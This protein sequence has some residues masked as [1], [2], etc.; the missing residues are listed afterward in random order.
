MLKEV[1]TKVHMIIVDAM[2]Y[3]Q[4]IQ[5]AI[6]KGKMQPYQRLYY[7]IQELTPALERKRGS[8]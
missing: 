6:D 2:E 5:Y 8:D 4:V 1:R 7:V 3:E